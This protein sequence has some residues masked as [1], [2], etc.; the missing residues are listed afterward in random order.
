MAS[1][2]VALR[3]WLRGLLFVGLWAMGYWRLP[4]CFH[5]AIVSDSDIKSTALGISKSTDFFKKI[6]PPSLFVFYRLS[7]YIADAL[8]LS[9]QSYN[10][11]LKYTNIFDIL[12]EKGGIWSR[13]SSKY[14]IRLKIL[15][16]N[17]HKSCINL[18]FVVSLQQN[19][20][21][22]PYLRI[23]ILYPYSQMVLVRRYFYFFY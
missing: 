1:R 18:K 5:F 22:G 3:K 17:R 20:K 16:K 2:N 15:N 23:L 7:F 14:R 4:P 10:F 9:R 12:W 21:S 6:V 11:F 13:K 8:Y 19:T